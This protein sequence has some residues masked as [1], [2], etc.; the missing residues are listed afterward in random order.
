MCYESF[1]RCGIHAG[2]G[3]TATVLNFADGGG[4]SFLLPD[5]GVS[6]EA[7]INGDD[8]FRFLFFG[9]DWEQAQFGRLKLSVPKIDFL[10]DLPLRDSLEKMGITDVFDPE[11]A[12]FS[13]TLSYENPPALST[14]R[15]HARLILNYVRDHS[16]D[17]TGLLQ[18]IFWDIEDRV[19]G[20]AV[21]F[22]RYENVK[23]Q[24]RIYA[25]D[26]NYPTIETYFYMDSSGSVRQAPHSVFDTIESIGLW[27]CRKYFELVQNH[28]KTRAIYMGVNDAY[29]EGYP[30]A[31]IPGASAEDPYV[32]YT[33][34]KNL[35]RVIITPTRNNASFMYMDE[36]YSFGEITENTRG[37]L[38]FPNKIPGAAGA[39]THEVFR[40]FEDVPF[41]NPDYVL[42]ASLTEIGESAFEGTTA[43]I[44]YL[45]DT[46]A[47]I[48]EYAFRNA[49]IRQIRIPA[50]CQIAV[51]A[52]AGCEDV[53][54][55]G[56][57][58]S[59][60]EN[61]CVWDKNCTFVAEK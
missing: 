37:E 6:P 1:R 12:Q 30:Y 48:G 23:G 16:Y 52:F 59:P 39:A 58:G 20:H 19:N 38:Y 15:Q 25:Y 47:N 57:P 29:I 46:C 51:S 60:A 17:E 32:V 44:V 26:N 10:T 7:L 5:E 21:N 36:E 45:P 14:L 61:F 24:D 28:D 13:P 27:D 42:P 18:I 35:D 54:I 49:A 34:P 40:I 33:I 22:L 3:F 11:K 56:T 9:G 53:I 55:F 41:G 50:K 31:Y 43:K 4:V 8:A 2:D